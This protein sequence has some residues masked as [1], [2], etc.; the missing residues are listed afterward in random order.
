MGKNVNELISAK[1]SK[2]VS[3]G[4]ARKEAVAIALSMYKGKLKDDKKGKK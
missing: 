1:I 2:L 4:K 3:E